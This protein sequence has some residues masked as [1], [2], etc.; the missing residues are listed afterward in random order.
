MRLE[1]IPRDTYFCPVNVYR[2][3]QVYYRGP[4]N[5]DVYLVHMGPDHVI[6][7]ELATDSEL[8]PIMK[9][10]FQMLAFRP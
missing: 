5:G 2:S 7:H 6:T 9:A 1:E 8:E 3:Q 4:Q 10:A